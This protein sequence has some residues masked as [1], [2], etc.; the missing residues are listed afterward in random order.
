MTVL[1]HLFLDK[2]AFF[3]GPVKALPPDITVI[4]AHPDWDGFI[5]RLK[6]A[7]D[8][9]QSRPEYAHPS[10]ATVDLIEKSD[11]YLFQGREEAGFC[12]V[13]LA[14][15]FGLPRPCREIH[16]FALYPEN[17]GR[18]L[19]GPCLQFVLGDIF[20]RAATVYLNTRDSNRV[21]SI[22]FYQRLGFQLFRQEKLTCEAV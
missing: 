8:N 11:L 19:G 14:P 6:K 13:T 21:N 5:A 3:Q 9:W 15:D 4:K 10:P 7:G 12:Y 2:Q 17:T 1:S 18:G 22:P 20:T 16:K